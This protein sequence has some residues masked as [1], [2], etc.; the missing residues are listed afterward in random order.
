MKNRMFAVVS[1]LA[2]LTLPSFGQQSN[3]SASDQSAPAMQVTEGRERL[4]A[5]KRTNFWDG[6]DPNFWNLIAHPF[7][8]KQYV[9]RYTAPIKDRLNELDEIK[10]E[11]ANKA[12]DLD[13]RS[14]DALKLASEKV[15]AADQ[16][17]MDAGSR[18]QGAQSTSTQASNHVASVEQMVANLD[19]YKDTAQT[20][21][22]FR[23]GQTALSKDAKD[24]LD[25]LA[26]PLDHQK[27]YMIEVRGFSAGHGSA[28]IANSQRLADSV[29]RYLALTHRIPIYRI[30]TITMGDA[31]V[32][33]TKHISRDRVEVSVLRNEAVTLGQR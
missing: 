27:N 5:P 28:A 19:Q 6:D 22:R 29:M 16:H 14:Q 18:A 10:T 25:Q 9:Q 23:P 33:Q 11:D 30:R 21:I 4:T 8:D 7:A 3:P 1:L 31:T 12:K 2:I 32:A 17:A 24:A 26:A 20:E 15:S 13:A